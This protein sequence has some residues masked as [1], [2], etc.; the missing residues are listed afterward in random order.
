MTP[1]RDDLPGSDCPL[2]REHA[3]FLDRY[4][5][6]ELLTREEVDNIVRKTVKETLYSLGIDAADPIEMQRDFQTLRD[7]RR[8]SSS[9]RA[10]GTMT[11]IAIITAGVMGALWIGVKS[12]L[13][14]S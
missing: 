13:F 6:R 9:V 7:W 5:G 11:A 10:K 8:A 3:Q 2:Y 4:A 12:V 1:P 14:K